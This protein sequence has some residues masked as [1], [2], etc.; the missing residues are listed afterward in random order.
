MY[1]I[2]YTVRQNQF[3]FTPSR[4]LSVGNFFR[5]GTEI[6]GATHFWFDLQIT[7][8]PKFFCKKSLSFNLSLKCQKSEACLYNGH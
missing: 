2:T 5:A 4:N 8:A 3:T 6:T 1:S 7:E